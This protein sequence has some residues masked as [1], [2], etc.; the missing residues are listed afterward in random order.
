MYCNRDVV[1]DLLPEFRHEPAAEFKF[2]TIDELGLHTCVVEVE[3]EVV[4]TLIVVVV[5]AMAAETVVVGVGTRG[6]LVELDFGRTFTQTFL[7]L[8]LVQTI[9]FP[10]MVFLTPTF[11]HAG[12]VA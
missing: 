1:V 5:V 4:F 9:F 2:A 12:E 11:G 3:V 10:L 8:T 7:P 6:V